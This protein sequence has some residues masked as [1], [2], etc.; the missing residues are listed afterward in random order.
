MF[1]L[2]VHKAE[3]HRKRARMSEKKHF[4]FFQ[5]TNAAK[6]AWEVKLEIMDRPTDRPTRTDR[7]IGKFH[8]QYNNEA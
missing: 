6:G 3:C 2:E 7:V 4:S 5:L 8:F 1:S